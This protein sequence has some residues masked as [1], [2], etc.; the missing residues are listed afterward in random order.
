MM[1]MR[2][3]IMMSGAIMIVQNIRSC[4]HLIWI[5]FDGGNKK[6]KHQNQYDSDNFFVVN[7]CQSCI[8]LFLWKK[9]INI[10]EEKK[11]LMVISFCT[12]M[13]VSIDDRMLSI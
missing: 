2:S 12:T 8:V 1:M 4:G 7:S 10:E 11:T 13:I 5:I 6:E 9:S 3:I